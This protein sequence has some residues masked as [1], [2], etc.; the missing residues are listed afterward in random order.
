MILQNVENIG[1]ESFRNHVDRFHKLKST[2]AIMYTLLFQF[3]L[4]FAIIYVIL[5]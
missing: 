1:Y 4:E 2:I 5:R 3:I